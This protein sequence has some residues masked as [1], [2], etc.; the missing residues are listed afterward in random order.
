MKPDEVALY[1]AIR[2]IG[3]QP[4]RSAIEAASVKLGVALKRTDYLLGKWDRKGWWDFGTSLWSGWFTD[5]APA[6]LDS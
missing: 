6:A 3:R 1:A 2:A 4:A 5:D